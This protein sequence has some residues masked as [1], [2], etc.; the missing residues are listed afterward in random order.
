MDRPQEMQHGSG[1]LRQL[2]RD[3][4]QADRSAARQDYESARS[5]PRS[6]GP[7]RSQ[8]R[9]VPVTYEEGLLEDFSLET[10]HED[11]LPIEPTRQYNRGPRSNRDQLE[12]REQNWILA[13]RGLNA[14]QC[15]QRSSTAGYLKARHTA[16][17]DLL[18][19]AIAA[20]RE[21][22][23][24]QCHGLGKHTEAVA[25]GHRLVVYHSMDTSRTISI[26]VFTC[27]GCGVF[28]MPATACHCFPSSPVQPTQ[29][30]DINLLA[31]YSQLYAHSG[32]S[33]TAFC[34]SLAELQQHLR[35]LAGE[36][37]TGPELESN[38]FSGIWVKY[39]QLSTMN[40]LSMHV[41]ANDEP[42]EDL[43]HNQQEY[44][45]GVAGDCPVCAELPDNNIDLANRAQIVEGCHCRLNLGALASPPES[46]HSGLEEAIA[47]HRHLLPDQALRD[48]AV[49]EESMSTAQ[50][51][52]FCVVL[53][54]NQ[55]MNHYQKCGATQ[56]AV[57]ESL[58]LTHPD[59]IPRFTYFGHLE[60]A[61]PG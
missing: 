1:S 42:H 49:A 45:P 21:R 35:L 38:L 27:S 52:P 19:Q 25:T 8:R 26:P 4:S 55:K 33:S 48:Q 2:G 11:D 23:L 18:E 24:H 22:P 10:D 47:E 54:G 3:V 7:S 13:L 59:S 6:R 32:V 58:S 12:A 39:I 5:A 37:L 14:V 56:D 40:D 34:Q 61:L 43:E 15:Y 53:D 30:I 57:H 51:R 44:S 17:I 16:E 9:P 50:Q 60:S 41:P 29:W 46:G 28:E 20:Y 36:D 31:H